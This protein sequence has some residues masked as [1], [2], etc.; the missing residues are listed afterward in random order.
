MYSTFYSYR[1]SFH[2]WALTSPILGFSSAAS[3]VSVTLTRASPVVD[4][5]VVI[6]LSVDFCLPS[7][8][9]FGIVFDSGWHDCCC[10][11]VFGERECVFVCVIAFDFVSFLILWDYRNENIECSHHSDKWWKIERNT[12]KTRYEALIVA[13]WILQLVSNKVFMSQSWLVVVFCIAKVLWRI[14]S[15]WYHVQ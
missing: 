8:D 13:F 12:F 9:V 3:Q 11:D 6:V 15:F 2:L 14:H 7:L 5:E 4:L 1:S 10:W